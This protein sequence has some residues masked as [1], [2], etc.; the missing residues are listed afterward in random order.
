MQQWDRDCRIAGKPA[1]TTISKTALN[2]RSRRVFGGG[3]QKKAAPEGEFRSRKQ[4]VPIEAGSEVW[5]T[6]LQG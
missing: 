6:N 1:L 2:D 4:T 3:R 5:G